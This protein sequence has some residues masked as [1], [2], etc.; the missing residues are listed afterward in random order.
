[1]KKPSHLTSFMLVVCLFF[2]WGLAHHLNPI[3]ILHLKKTCQLNDL[4]SAFID[5]VFF[6]AY[7]VITLPAE[8]VIKRFGFKNDTYRITIVCYWRFIVCFGSQSKNI[9]VFSFCTFWHFIQV[10]VFEKQLQ[11]K[12]LHT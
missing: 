5:S 1:M 2:L 6:I 11:S 10:N 3:L 7:F 9:L 8:F 4:Q 12:P